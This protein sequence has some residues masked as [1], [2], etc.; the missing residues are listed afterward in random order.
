M[1]I[2]LIKDGI[3]KKGYIGFS[4][5]VLFLGPYIAAHRKDYKWATIMTILAACTSCAAM[6]VFGFIYNNIYTKNLL[7]AGFVPA[8]D[9]SRQALLDAGIAVE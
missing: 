9:Y 8:D 3:K 2:T 1:E 6:L 4:L 7:K 5:A